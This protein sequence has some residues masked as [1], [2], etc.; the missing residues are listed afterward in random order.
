MNPP[1]ESP[2]RGLARIN[3]RHV[4]SD[5]LTARRRGTETRVGC[6][7]S[8]ADMDPIGAVVHFESA[9]SRPGSIGAL[10]HFETSPLAAGRTYRLTV[11]PVDRQCFGDPPM[12]P[13]LRMEGKNRLYDG[14]FEHIRHAEPPSAASP[15]EGS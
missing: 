12:R 1:A 10:V 9:A 14:H 3:S 11:S 8:A 2:W 15:L 13:T 5:W 6:A 4:R 7:D